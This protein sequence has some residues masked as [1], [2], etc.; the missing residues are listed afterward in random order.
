MIKFEMQSTAIQ[1]NNNNN[2]NYDTECGNREV[3][4]EAQETL[5]ERN[6]EEKGGREGH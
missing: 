2:K 1:D 5:K 3:E 4:R 6:G